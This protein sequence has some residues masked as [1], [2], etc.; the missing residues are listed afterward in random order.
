M[1]YVA[2]TKESS[3]LARKTPVQ[4]RYQHCYPTSCFNCVLPKIVMVMVNPTD[5]EGD[6]CSWAIGGSFRSGTSF[7]ELSNGLLSSLYSSI[8]C[9]GEREQSNGRKGTMYGDFPLD[10]EKDCLSKQ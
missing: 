3:A 2:V 5:D 9:I 7:S 10:V 6:R 4:S 1:L 8:E